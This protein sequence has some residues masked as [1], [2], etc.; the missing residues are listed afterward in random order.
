MNDKGA[1]RCCRFHSIE[2]INYNV[3]GALGHDFF[4]LKLECV[5]VEMC[6]S[7]GFLYVAE[8]EWVCDALSENDAD[9]VPYFE[10]KVHVKDFITNMVSLSLLPYTFF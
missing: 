5:N 8:P 7:N 1:D 9:Y 6:S 4:L 2:E 10:I 3:N